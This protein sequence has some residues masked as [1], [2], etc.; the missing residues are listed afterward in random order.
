MI[1]DCTKTIILENER[2]RLEPIDWKHFDALLAIALKHPSL[3]LY[4]PSLINSDVHMRNY[5]E[6]AILQREQKQRY[7][8]VIFD[9]TKNAYAGSTSFGNISNEN[10]RVEIGWTWLG[11]EFQRTGLNQHCKF[12][13]L[14]YAFEKLQFKRVELKTDARN[15]QSRKAIEGIGAIYEGALRSHTIMSDGHRRDTVYYSIL[16]DEWGRVKDRFL[17]RL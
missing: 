17:D 8:F 2:A 7:A 10:L 4:S 13:L 11:K 12:L 16:S 14:Q 15:Q 3:L 1:L 6:K 5:F 9:K